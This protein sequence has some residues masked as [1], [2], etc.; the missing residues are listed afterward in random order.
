MYFV[1]HIRVN[2]DTN[3]INFVTGWCGVKHNQLRVGTQRIGRK[4]LVLALVSDFT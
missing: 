1:K 3:Y 2:H 4:T